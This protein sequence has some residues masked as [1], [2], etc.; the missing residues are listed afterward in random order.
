MDTGKG[1]LEMIDEK[2]AEQIIAVGKTGA[3]V[4]SVFSIGEIL[5]IKQSRFKVKKITPKGLTLRV[6][7]KE[8]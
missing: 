2:K 7:P 3:R 1:Y 5:E 4:P 8:D 6:L